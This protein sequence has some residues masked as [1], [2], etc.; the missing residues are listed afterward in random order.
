MDVILK[1]VQFLK[2][3]ARIV[4]LF[5]FVFGLLL[6]LP[7]SIL[8]TLRLSEFLTIASPYIGI[9]FVLSVGYLV[10]TYIPQLYLHFK[11][12]RAEREQKEHLEQA[13]KE[14]SVPEKNLL[15]EF[16]LQ[17]NDTIEVP[18]EQPVVAGLLHKGILVPVSRN[19]NYYVFGTF[20]F[21]S[22]NS[23]IRRMITPTLLELPNQN[24][25]PTRKEIDDIKNNRPDFLINL[26][27]INSIKTGRRYWGL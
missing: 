11:K 5:A 10:F 16:Y 26:N 24:R 3:P 9:V 13:V 4:A 14:L 20:V 18:L 7:E 19:A 22:V 6:F 23:S 17:G 12:R 15:R 27:W 1:I 8:V 21:V 25:K 2:A